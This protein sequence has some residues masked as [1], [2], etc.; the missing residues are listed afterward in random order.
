MIEVVQYTKDK[1]KDWDEFVESSEAYSF[2]FIRKYLEYHSDRFKDYSLM[3]YAKSKLIALLP[4]NIKD[5]RFYSHQGLT[6]GGL[7]SKDNLGFSKCALI[8]E[9]IVTFLQK[10][11]IFHLTLKLQPFF[12]SSTFNQTITYLLIN[13]ERFKQT[14][15]I[16]AHIRCSDHLFPKRC[17]R[18]G[19]LNAYQLY[20]SD[21]FKSFWKILNE[22]LKKYHNAIAVHSIEEIEKLNSRFPEN[23]RLAFI[24]SNESEEIHAGAVL[25]ESNEVVKVQYFA[26]S[27]DGRSNR[28][29]DVLYYK[30][31]E[32]Y[33][34]SSRFIDFGTNSNRDGSINSTLISTKEKFGAVIHPVMSYEASF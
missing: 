9:E 19:K 17:V 20:F 25:F 5:N 34:R 31:I 7:I 10:H 12:Y 3:L 32:Y 1:E 29:S 21:D 26:T 33:K 27:E 2:I 18:V 24:K 14:A 8:I 6:Y 16:G 28:A 23:I 13:D 15:D 22:N 30:L 4:G 11:N